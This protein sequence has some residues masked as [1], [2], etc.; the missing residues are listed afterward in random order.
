VL[1]IDLIFGKTLVRLELDLIERAVFS[2]GV[3]DCALPRLIARQDRRLTFLDDVAWA[4]APQLAR[5]SSALLGA[6][7][8]RPGNCS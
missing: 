3:P 5:S 8:P 7:L 6:D 1:R 4:L 2:I